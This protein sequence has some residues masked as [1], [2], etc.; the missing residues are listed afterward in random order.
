MQSKA[1]DLDACM[2]EVP[3]DRRELLAG[4]RELARDGAPAPP[5]TCAQGS[6]STY[7]FAHGVNAGSTGLDNR[8]SMT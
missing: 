5:I 2:D 1:V 8:R 3:E 7:R 6:I 4:L